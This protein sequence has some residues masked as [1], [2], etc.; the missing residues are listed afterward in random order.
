MAGNGAGPLTSTLL[1]FPESAA[2]TVTS[3]RRLGG[4]NL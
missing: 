2:G 4:V 3:V 1:M